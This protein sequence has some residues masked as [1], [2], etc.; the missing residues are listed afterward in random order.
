MKCNQSPVG[1]EFVSPC[2]FPTTITI[3]PR[4]PPMLYTAQSAGAVEYT[5]CISA[6]GQTLLNKYT[7]YDTKQSNGEALVMLD[8]RGMQ[9]TPSLPSFPA[10]L[11]PGVVAPERVLSMHQIELFAIQTV[12]LC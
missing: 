5:S 6:E 4:V 7:G 2:P 12:Y 3:T 9:N 10:P 11:W 1:F 8:L